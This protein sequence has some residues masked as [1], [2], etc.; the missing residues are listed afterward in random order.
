MRI[1][2]LIAL[3]TFA[4][5]TLGFLLFTWH[6]EGGWQQGLIVALLIAAMTLLAGEIRGQ[7]QAIEGHARPHVRR[8]TRGST[9]TGAR[10]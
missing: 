4:A 5:A 7:L 2:H 6:A 8:Q 9:R 10:S 1:G 3:L